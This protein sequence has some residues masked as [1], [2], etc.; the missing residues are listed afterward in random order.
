MSMCQ[1][2]VPFILP[3]ANT[4]GDDSQ[5][6]VLH[7]GLQNIS[8]TYCDEN[9]RI[10]T[11]TLTKLDCPL[12]SCLSLNT[13]TPWQ[14]RLLNKMLSPQQ[15]TFWHE[16]LEGGD[17]TQRVSQGMV[18][19]SWYLPSGRGNE[20]FKT[21]VT[22]VNLCGNARQHPLVK[23]QLS[24]LST[25][26]CMFTNEINQEVFT[27]LEKYVGKAGLKKI[28]L[29]ILYDTD[30][31]RKVRSAKMCDM[32]Q[33]RLKL[34]DYQIVKGPL[35]ESNFHVT[36]D[37][38]QDSLKTSFDRNI[39][40]KTSLFRLVDEVKSSGC[41]KVDDVVCYEGHNAAQRILSEIDAI[42]SDDVKSKILPCQSD[43]KTREKIGK[44]EKEICRQKDINENDLIIQYVAKKK[45]NKWQLHWKQLQYPISDIFTHFLWFI[46]NFDSVNRKYFLHS[47]KL[48]LDERSIEL[49]QPL[50]EEYQKCRLE[51]KSEKTDRKLK[52]L[53]EQLTYSSLGLEHF[54]REMAV[55]YENMV[56]LC[57][58]VPA[59]ENQLEEILDTLSKTMANILVEGEAI[60]ILDGD[61]VHSPVVWLK[62]VL[63][64]IENSI[65]V[66]VFKISTL[67]AQSS[68]KSTLLNAVFGLN[69]PVSSGRCTRGAYMQMVKIDKQLSQ[70]LKCNYLLIIDSEGLMSRV[71]KS[72]D[73]D[74]EL[75]TFVIGL[76][77]LTLVFIKGEGKEMEDVLP[78]AIHVFLRMNVLGELQ[79]CHFVHQNMGAVDVKKTMPIEID[80]FVQLLD[81]KMD[82]K[83]RAAAKEAW[84]KKYTRFTDVLYYDKNE[85]NTY[86][87]GLWDGN[88]P[89]GKTAIEYSDTML[90]L[91]RTVVE[92]IESVVQMNVVQMKH[93]STLKDFSRWLEVIWE[94]VKY[95]NFVFSFRNVLAVEAYNR[96]S[97]ILN[98]RKWEIKTTIRENMEKEKKELKDILMTVKN[99]NKVMKTI[100]I[101][102]GKTLE[103]ITDSTQH[104][105]VCILHYFQCPGC[106]DENC[107]E[108]VRN[109]QFLRDYK[110]QFEHDILRF[111]RC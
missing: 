30:K 15:D 83:T 36:Y 26:T 84:K 25:T 105:M 13:N 111:Q 23:E 69:F 99:T 64:Q 67:G 65:K 29:V 50:Y 38:L 62:A 32:L 33:K 71:S 88:P 52:E 21:P 1:Y 89:M 55:M 97:R 74:N 10:V 82:E 110:G 57:E 28:I 9:K 27:F 60:E 44:L 102:N 35:H 40:G 72:D 46:T 76:S 11:K 75:A 95:E 87:C 68:G 109:R 39:G 4:N 86:V 37:N 70:R 3:S 8:R 108:E 94:A 7:W 19:V 77:D 53:N 43:I 51:E 104:L 79:A 66:K 34:Q 101:M 45:E 54:F 59:E 78:I 41:M 100:D 98:D 12:V 73:Y 14:S 61:V 56:A 48:G 85:D 103:N 31:G 2:A 106:Q 107:D 20:K 5:C 42:E 24:R 6:T 18:E 63:N 49:L 81:E 58:K 16:G 93:C 80:T 47:L 90:R 22:F 92:R 17:R 96:L 91:K